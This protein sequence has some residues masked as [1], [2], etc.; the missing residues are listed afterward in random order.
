M[1]KDIRQLFFLTIGI[2]VVAG[3]L[4]CR[5]WDQVEFT[6][7]YGFC[8]GYCDT[9]VQLDTGAEGAIRH[10]G[11]MVALVTQDVS[12]P[13]RAGELDDAVDQARSI[14]WEARYGCPDCF[15]QG[16]YKLTVTTDG[17]T[18][19]TEMDPSDHP[20]VFDP[21]I[22]FFGRIRQENPVPQSQ[23]QN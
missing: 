16:V 22:E 13:D 10:S 12:Y 15:D 7:S 1:L 6:A 2:G 18:R 9:A 14:S 21:I 20:D 19:T 8:R 3:G 5:S 17:E 4:S 23:P 11:R